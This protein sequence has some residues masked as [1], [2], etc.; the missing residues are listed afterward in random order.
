M[1][2]M[3]QIEIRKDYNSFDHNLFCNNAVYPLLSYHEAKQLNMLL[4][5]ISN[6]CIFVLC[7]G[8]K[9]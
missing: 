3:R 8:V 5:N 6:K 1:T 4:Y 9:R 7:G 2:S